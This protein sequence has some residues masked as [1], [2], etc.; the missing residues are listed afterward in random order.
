MIKK[1]PV[2]ALQ[3]GMFVCD[4]NA[5]WLNHPFLFNQLAIS[6]A[7]EIAK[8]RDSGVQELFIDTDKGL[9]AASADP[10]PGATPPGVADGSEPVAAEGA[11]EGSTEAAAEKSVAAPDAAE[12]RAPAAGRLLRPLSIADELGRARQVYAQATRLVKDMLDNARLGKQIDLEAMRPVVESITGSVLRNSNAMMTLTRLQQVGDETFLHSLGVS[13]LMVAFGKSLGM[14]VATLH[15][16]AL[17]GLLHD[18]GK[19]RVAPEILGKTSPLTDS[20]IR[21]LKSHVAQGAVIASQLP[22]ISSVA[23]AI[24][25]QHH[26][27]YDGSGYPRGLQGEAIAHAGRVAAIVDVYDVITSPHTYRKQD[28]PTE[29]LRNLFALSAGHFDPQLIKAFVRSIGVYPVGSLV[30]LSSGRL[31]VVIA[32]NEDELLLPQ[33][34][35]IFDTHSRRLLLP[36]NI[37]LR[38]RESHGE[39]IVAAESGGKWGIDPMLFLLD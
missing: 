36:E 37:D 21:Y 13:V 20:E 32:V 29:A 2:D 33:V 17:G 9:D 31:A 12:T 1:I 30:R 10:V 28:A 23:L 39:A 24:V 4:F 11:A 14:D 18:V 27:R 15:Q 16:Y 34:R 8:V 22:G 25:E 5:S 6:S 26:E 19:T 3:I 38:Q 35:I 7:E